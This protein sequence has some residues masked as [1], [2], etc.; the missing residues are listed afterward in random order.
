MRGASGRRLDL[1]SEQLTPAAL[2]PPPRGQWTW[3]LRR[4]CWIESSVP[5]QW[6]P[7]R[8]NSAASGSPGQYQVSCQRKGVGR[9]QLVRFYINEP[10]HSSL[11]TTVNTG[12]GT[13]DWPPSVHL[14]VSSI[15]QTLMMGFWHNLEEWYL[16]TLSSD[17][18]TVISLEMGVLHC[19][20]IQNNMPIHWNTDVQTLIK[21]IQNELD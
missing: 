17:I 19:L 18:F 16:G 8:I 11:S 5:T 13:M 12:A 15:P 1:L 4:H 2:V 14:C 7:L 3:L 20:L 9:R 10:C 6:V 21:V